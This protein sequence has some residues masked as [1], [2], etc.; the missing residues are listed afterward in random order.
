MKKILLFASALAGLF[1]AGSCQKENFEAASAKGSVTFTVEVPGGIATKGTINDGATIADGTNVNVVHYALYKTADSD[2]YAVNGTGNAPLA[3]GYVGMELKVIDGKQVNTATVTFDLLQDQEYTA[4]FW[5]QVGDAEGQNAHYELGDLRVIRMKNGADANDESRAAFYANYEFNTKEHKNHKVTLTRPFSQLNL[6]TT[7]ESLTPTQTGQTT[8]Y[9]IDIK[10]SKVVVKGIATAFD[11][12]KDIA[13]EDSI[14]EYTFSLAATPEEQGQEELTVNG[15]AYHYVSMNYF[16]VPFNATTDLEVSYEIVTDKGA[17]SNSIINVPIKTNHRTN[18]IGNLLT[19]ETVFD[20]VVDEKF[21]EP[22]LPQN[23]AENLG[24]AAQLGG[25]VT[26]TEDVV[27]TEPLVVSNGAVMVLDLNGNSLTG[28]FVNEG[29]LIIKGEG[30]ISN[31]ADYAV[32]NTGVLVIDAADFSGLGGI[33]SNAGKVTINGGSFTASSDW[34]KG[35]YNHILK[36]KNTEAV[37]N[38]GEFDATVGGTTN[39]MINVSENAVLTINGGSFKNVNGTIPQFAPYMFTYEENGKLVIN[40]GT[41]YG[42]WRFN[43]VTTTTDI[44]GGD[45]AVSYDGQSFH[46]SSTHV[47]T[48]YGGKFSTDNGAKLNPTAYVAEGFVVKNSGTSYSVFPD[49][50]GVDNMVLHEE[51]G[52]LY[53]GNN[54]YSKGVYYLLSESDLK[55]A[56]EYFA[57][58][59]HSNEGN[60]CTLELNADMDM[61]GVNW[62][63]WNVMFIKINANGHKIANLNNCLF[64]YAG[65][66]TVNDLTLEN[67]TS[68]GN[69]AG[70]FA[71]AVEGTTLNNC[72]LKGDNK[73]TYVDAGKDEN[74]IGAIAG[75]TINSNLNVEIAAGATVT[76]E[77]NGIADT[78]KTTFNSYL[79]GYKHT[80]YATNSGVVTVYGTL[81]LGS[82]NYEFEEAANGEVAVTLSANEAGAKTVRSVVEA[83]SNLTSAIVAEG[84]EVIGNRTFRR[85]YGL[86]TITLPST[87][88]EIA[89]GAFQSC[90]SLKSV[91]IPA[92]VTAIGDQAFYGCTSLTEVNIPEGISRIEASAFRDIAATEIT[93]PSTVS[94]IGQYAFRDNYQMTKLTILSE[95]IETIE[96]GAFLKSSGTFPKM[97]IYVKNDAVKAKVEAVIASNYAE[98]VLM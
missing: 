45:F 24:L 1:L 58:Q 65:A 12:R 59:N 29:E 22:D 50:D 74:G 42:G 67:V 25:T 14:G 70:T 19:K 35:T 75:V 26:L 8:G 36:V 98:V 46:A 84:I 97:T 79:W 33:R 66:V 83:N 41:F 64:G 96:A 95:N 88:T 53:N 54:A 92:S 7:K 16:F 5:S 39:A 6:L 3:Q 21:L 90:S 94:F 27:L 2:A 69:Q 89:S 85:C 40:D 60:I 62:N 28:Q 56:T 9:T 51:S 63:P 30:S 44:Y 23:V 4:I 73:V 93:V 34:N 48:V 91:E 38:G 52:L 82:V 80:T 18:I 77:Y 86:E 13:L 49:V 15:N 76:L 43:G 31:D 32:E 87:L 55:K 81:N 47:L 10:E 68:A 11:T 71:A 72:V 37:I 57:G 61:S 17:M 20:I 78:A